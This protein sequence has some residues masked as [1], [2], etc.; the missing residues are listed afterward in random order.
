MEKWVWIKEKG[1]YKILS[2]QG[3]EFGDAKY[4]KSS[5]LDADMLIRVL[6]SISLGVIPIL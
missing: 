6:M 4:P 2:F 3:K 1:S 5:T